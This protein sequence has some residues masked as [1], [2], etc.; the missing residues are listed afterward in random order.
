MSILPE[1]KSKEKKASTGYLR[2]RFNAFMAKAIFP[3]ATRFHVVATAS[4]AMAL[5][6]TDLVAKKTRGVTLSHASSTVASTFASNDPTNGSATKLKD[7][8]ASGLN[9]PTGNTATIAGSGVPSGAL[10]SI[11]NLTGAGNA[12]GAFAASQ[13]ATPAFDCTVL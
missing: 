2:A 12:M 11:S 1:T 10:F 3:L 8:L 4:P 6:T 9:D 5:V 7:T 13:S